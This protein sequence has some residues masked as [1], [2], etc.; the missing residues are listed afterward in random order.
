M[1]IMNF[2]I[3]DSDDDDT[4]LSTCNTT[5]AIGGNGN[6]VI[7]SFGSVS[8][9]F[10]DS[11]YLTASFDSVTLQSLRSIEFNE[12]AKLEGSDTITSFSSV[13]VAV[14]GLSND[15]IECQSDRCFIVGDTGNGR[16][17]TNVGFVLEARDTVT[18][19]GNNIVG[20][21]TIR[22]Q[23]TSQSMFSS[24][25]LVRR[26]GVAC[27]A[28]DHTEWTYSYSSPCDSLL[29]NYLLTTSFIATEQRSI[30]VAGSGNDQVTANEGTSMVCADDCTGMTR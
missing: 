28:N 13:T 21:D 10:G 6:D 20:N 3:G 15:F 14:G 27:T 23:S 18:Q 11:I 2:G 4:I 30:V 22:I 12:S 9:L 19:T 29:D 1:H 16:L 5:I 26:F 25:A 24:A 7:T 8:A 17:D